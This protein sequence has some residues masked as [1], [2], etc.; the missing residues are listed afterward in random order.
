MSDVILYPIRGQ[1]AQ[2]NGKNEYIVYV[3]RATKNTYGTI[4]IGNG[5]VEENGVISVDL[6]NVK[7][8]SISLNDNPIEPDDTKRVNI[9]VNADTVGL[10]NVDNTSDEDKLASKDVRDKL[11]A[12]EHNLTDDIMN[13]EEHLDNYKIEV[14]GLLDT[15]AAEVDRKLDIVNNTITTNKNSVDTEL[16]KLNDLVKGKDMALAYKNYSEVI[17]EFNAAATNKYKVGQAVFIQDTMV[18]DLWV[19]SVENTHVD[20]VYIG[21]DN[22]VETLSSVGTV[23]FGYYKLAMLETKTTSVANAVTLDT[24]QTITGAKTFSVGNSYVAIQ[25][26]LATIQNSNRDDK[27]V[28]MVYVTKNTAQLGST[29]STGNSFVGITHT[30]RTYDTIATTSITGKLTYNGK[31]VATV[32]QIGG[33]DVN[34]LSGLIEDSDTIVSSI[35]DDK[36]KLELG[37]TVQN[38]LAK[39]LIVPMSAPSTTELVAVNNTNS[40]T[41]IEIGEG[42]TLDNG[43]L[44]ATGGTVDL[45]NAVTLDGEQTVTGRKSFENGIFITK[46]SDAS[47]AYPS[48]TLLRVDDSALIASSKWNDGNRGVYFELNSFQ[49]VKLGSRD[50]IG[51]N[52]KGITIDTS[53]KML[54]NDYEVATKQ[55]IETNII[56][57]L[58]TEV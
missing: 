17:N 26:N 46:E 6:T 37:S 10:G 39:S 2:I 18:P 12:L 15:A 14:N 57:A 41:M 24:S 3:P 55:D 28:S 45:S 19:Y 1:L 54:Y 50:R 27:N 42:L 35:L 25:E 47:D 36:I 40:Q 20:F 52:F 32:D 16:L 4:K 33:L 34:T 58:N 9:V 5:L 49:G 56:T 38:T 43:V 7:I 31:E 53:G 13:V 21:N 51:D 22:I 30:P 48:F 11:T 44:K 23:Q 8:D 29:D